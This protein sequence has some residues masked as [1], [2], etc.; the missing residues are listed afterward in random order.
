VPTEKPPTL[1]TVPPG[2]LESSATKTSTAS[3]PGIGGG[4]RWLTIPS[5]GRRLVGA[6]PIVSTPAEAQVDAPR[7]ADG[8][9][10]SD[11]L[12][13]ADQVEPV[14]HTVEPGENFW[15]ISKL[16]YRQGRF[17][18][19]L[20]AANR[21]QVPDIRQLWV[22]T[23]LRIPP[24]EALDRN[25]IDP[26]DR[27]KATDE[28]APSLVRRTTKQTEPSDGADLGVAPRRRPVIVDPEAVATPRRPTYKVK[29]YE[30]LRSIARD[31]LNDPRRDREIF[32]LNRDVLDDISVPIP[33][34]TT[35]TLPSDA[36]VG[37][38]AAR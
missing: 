5:G 22:G 23:V 15:T 34:G 35:L 10:F 13:V 37:R 28:P 20:H 31:T 32:T 16:Y 30:T 1:E 27:S 19:A 21:K 12:A 3:M 26:P 17:Y 33:A 18:K 6:V 36:T 8:P 25:L 4:G 2:S 11:D 38:R 14:V 9:R 24:I 7:V 29:P